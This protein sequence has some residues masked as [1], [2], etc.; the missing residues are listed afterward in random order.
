MPK[1]G[2]QGDPKAR[3]DPAGRPVGRAAHPPLEAAPKRRCAL[4]N[5]H[6]PPHSCSIMRVLQRVASFG[7]AGALAASYYF[8]EDRV[9]EVGHWSWLVVAA[10]FLSAGL[11][12][13]W[14]I[15]RLKDADL[16]WTVEQ[17]RERRQRVDDVLEHRMGRR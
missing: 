11:W 13:E 2:G 4:A 17:E 16:V 6:P 10:I 15:K 3:L 5:R 1:L 12:A 9:L 8:A 14:R 7:F